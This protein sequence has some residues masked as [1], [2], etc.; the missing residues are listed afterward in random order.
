MAEP[1]PI[2]AI[3]ARVIGA[4]ERVSAGLVAMSRSPKRDTTVP[5]QVLRDH[6][7]TVGEQARELR[8]MSGE[9]PARRAIPDR[10]KLAVLTGAFD[11]SANAFRCA[12]CGALVAKDAVDIGHK[13]PVARGGSN[14]LANLRAEC[15]RC[16]RSRGAAA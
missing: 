10:V 8:G 14:D 13:V 3:V 2:G 6:A 5:T 7:A 9:V 15:Q 16:N 1:E 4:L 11:A 12:C